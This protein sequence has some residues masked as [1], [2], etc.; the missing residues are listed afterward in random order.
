MLLSRSKPPLWVAVLVAPV[1]Y[2]ALAIAIAAIGY[3][4][5]GRPALVSVLCVWIA[6]AA[7]LL[8]VVDSY[9]VGESRRAV[10]VVGA[11]FWMAASFVILAV[12]AHGIAQL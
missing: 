8:I 7:R 2:N 4:A 6:S 5:I 11:L 12:I 9:K 1:F 10:A 3:V